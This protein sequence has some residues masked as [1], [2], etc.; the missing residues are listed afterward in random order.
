M[1]CV[2]ETLNKAFE[3]YHFQERSPGAPNASARLPWVNLWILVESMKPSQAKTNAHEWY[4]KKYAS[5]RGIQWER[6]W[7][8]LKRK[9][10]SVTKGNGGQT[11]LTIA[12]PIPMKQR[13]RPRSV[14]DRHS[15]ECWAHLAQMGSH[16]CHDHDIPPQ[17][18]HTHSCL[19]AVQTPPKQ[20]LTKPE[21]IPGLPNPSTA[22]PKGCCT[23]VCLVSIPE[24]VNTISEHIWPFP[25]NPKHLESHWPTLSLHAHLWTRRLSIRNRDRA[26]P[27]RL[28][29]FPIESYSFSSVLI[30]ICLSLPLSRSLL[31]FL[32]SVNPVFV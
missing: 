7:S 19:L 13:P 15:G 23:D 11:Y 31:S 6:R 22:F 8:L 14:P 5:N 32:S 30:I 17:P 9:S 29:V 4:P 20:S 1:C 28:A 18:S 2:N 10:T 26:K 24:A 21:P 3:T 25:T 12:T 16:S 27:E